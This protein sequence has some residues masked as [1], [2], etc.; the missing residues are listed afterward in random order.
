MI[1]Q[2]VLTLPCF[3][4]SLTP[5][6]ATK[7]TEELGSPWPTKRSSIGRFSVFLDAVDVFE[8]E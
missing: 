7:K 4:P 8:K 2:L 1:A 3:A 5:M 6:V